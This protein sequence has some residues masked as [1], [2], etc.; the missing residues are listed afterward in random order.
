MKQ[1]MTFFARGAW[2]AIVCFEFSAAMADR[3]KSPVN[4]SQPNPPAAVSSISRRVRGAATKPGQQ[5][6]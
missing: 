2:C 4:A 6:E 1:K 5:L 3:P